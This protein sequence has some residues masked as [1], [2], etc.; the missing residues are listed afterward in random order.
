MALV[1]STQVHWSRCRWIHAW[2]SHT[3]SS[4]SFFWQTLKREPHK[5]VRLE[6]CVL[7]AITRDKAYELS[8]WGFLVAFFPIF[9]WFS[10]P[11]LPLLPMPQYLP[12][13]SLS[14]LFFVE[15]IQNFLLPRII[16]K[17][18]LMCHLNE[19]NSFT[20]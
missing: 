3:L 8:L 19:M 9:L 13:K 2:A 17:T 12:S 16:K 4:Y 11:L 10:C 18:Y 7:M 1:C 14:L 6:A 5:L 15:I 20:S